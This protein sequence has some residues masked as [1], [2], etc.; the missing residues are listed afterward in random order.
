MTERKTSEAGTSAKPSTAVVRATG[1]ALSPA[2]AAARAVP[3]AAATVAREV[4]LLPARSWLLAERAAVMSARTFDL[5]D[6]VSELLETVWEMAA[7]SEARIRHVQ[8]TTLGPEHTSWVLSPKVEAL[9]A[10]GLPPEE[11]QWVRA[12]E[13]MV[14][15]Q[16]GGLL[17]SRE[18]VA[19]EVDVPETKLMDVIQRLEKLG[20]AGRELAGQLAALPGHALPLN[21]AR[22]ATADTAEIEKGTGKR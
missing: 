5:G 17:S 19:I 10:A 3:R 8:S 7:E 14:T 13:P 1:A 9:I 11:A 4:A 16:T 18:A 21:P 15:L 20:A 22:P 12:S 2:R 6:A